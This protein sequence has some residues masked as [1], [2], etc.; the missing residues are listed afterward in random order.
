MDDIVDVAL[1]VLITAGI[2]WC[3]RAASFDARTT[4][5]IKADSELLAATDHDSD[6]REQLRQDTRARFEH[7][8]L[9]R[10]VQSLR[11]ALVPT[12]LIISSLALAAC[13]Y[14][15]LT[16]ASARSGFGFQDYA[17]G[18]MAL[19][20]LAAE[21]IPLIWGT[22]IPPFASLEEEAEARRRKRSRKEA[23]QSRIGSSQ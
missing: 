13:V 2:S 9:Y 23:D 12:L 5:R 11:G 1:T 15:L 20:S 22:S 19:A 8:M 7:L 3:L 6:A 14:L 16:S 4:R 17:F 10:E 18:V 21:F